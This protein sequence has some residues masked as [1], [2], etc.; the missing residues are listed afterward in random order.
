NDG[1]ER[2]RSIWLRKPI[3]KSV[4]VA[5]ISSENCLTRLRSRMR[6]P[7]ATSIAGSG[8]FAVAFPPLLLRLVAN[9]AG[10]AAAGLRILLPPLTS[11]RFLHVHENRLHR[12]RKC[13]QIFILVKIGRNGLARNVCDHDICERRHRPDPKGNAMPLKRFVQA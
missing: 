5:T 9:L 10:F 6:R 1:D 8:G 2:P 7:T 4:W 12:L 11:N 3:D 13:D